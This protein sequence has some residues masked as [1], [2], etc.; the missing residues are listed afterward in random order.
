M[1]LFILYLVI[2]LFFMYFDDEVRE[3]MVVVM[4]EER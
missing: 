3:W 2:Y 1:I 4:C